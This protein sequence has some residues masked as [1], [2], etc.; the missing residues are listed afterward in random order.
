MPL[1]DAFTQLVGFRVSGGNWLSTA[2]ATVQTPANADVV[3][4]CPS[5]LGQG[6]S[7]TVLDSD[8][9]KLTGRR[10]TS[11][12]G[13]QIENDFAISTTI[14]CISGMRHPFNSVCASL[15]K[16]GVSLLFSLRFALPLPRC[17]SQQPRTKCPVP[18]TPYIETL[19]L[20]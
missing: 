6:L 5:P 16:Y 19:G 9:V 20:G 7:N 13:C 12:R 17:L 14:Q 4:H 2:H 15:S 18:R 11:Q 10:R 8:Q 3:L 1:F